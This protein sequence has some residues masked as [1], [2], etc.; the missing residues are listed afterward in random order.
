MTIAELRMTPPANG[1]VVSLSGVVVVSRVTSTKYGH[2]WV[3]DPGG[4]QY[5]GIQLFCNYGGTSPDCALTKTTIDALAAG[6]IVD[7]SGK[8][9]VYTPTSPANAPPQLEIDAPMIM[10]TGQT[11]PPVAMTVSAST[12]AKDQYST[13]SDPYKGAYVE[14][15]T[16]GPYHVTSTTAMEFQQS[17]T[18]PSG[19]GTTYTGFETNNGTTTLAIGL[20]FYQTVTYC[21]PGCYT[22]SNQVTTSQSWSK[23]SGIVEPASNTNGSIYLQLSPTADSD[24]TP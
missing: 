2:V 4:G 24:L 11:M 20:A 9:N 21:L 18:G 16:G 1:T 22:C 6:A 8:F 10:G 13:S 17:C 7:V 5:S 12:L 23:I 3:Q 19:A 15:A 14:V